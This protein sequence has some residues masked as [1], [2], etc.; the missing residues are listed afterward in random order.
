MEPRPCPPL[1]PDR[2]PLVVSTDSELTKTVVGLLDYACAE[3]LDAN[4]GL[5]KV[6]NVAE[7]LE[8]IHSALQES[9]LVGND[10]PAAVAILKGLEH[11]NPAEAADRVERAADNVDGSHSPFYWMRFAAQ[12]AAE[13]AKG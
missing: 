8:T 11:L 10:N 2:V 5:A 13:L 6:M 1:D 9:E 4:S 12:Q 7:Y 3:L